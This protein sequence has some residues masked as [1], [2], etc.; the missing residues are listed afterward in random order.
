MKFSCNSVFFCTF[1]PFSK[2]LLGSYCAPGVVLGIWD[3]GPCSQDA[4]ILEWRQAFDNKK[5]INEQMITEPARYSPG[6][7]EGSPWNRDSVDRV[8]SQHMPPLVRGQ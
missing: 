7:T 3:T 2:H 4:Y 5:W 6:W 8:A 1:D